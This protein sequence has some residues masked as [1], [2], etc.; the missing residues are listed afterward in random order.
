MDDLE[1]RRRTIA[2]PND[3]EKE[4]LE[5]AK[6]MFCTN[7]FFFPAMNGEQDGNPKATRK[8]RFMIWNGTKAAEATPSPIQSDI[9]RGRR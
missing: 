6:I 1:F 7:N 2:Q 8:F 9:W 4:L 5:F 3:L